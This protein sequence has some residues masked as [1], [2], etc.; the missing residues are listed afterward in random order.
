MKLRVA[1][2]LAAA[3]WN[4]GCHGSNNTTPTPPTTVQVVSGTPQT[5][6]VATAAAAPLVVKVLDENGG[7]AANLSVGFSTRLPASFTPPASTDA[8]GITQ[9]T[10]TA[11][12]TAGADTITATATGSVQSAI[13][14][15]TITPGPPD[16][17]R[18]LAGDGQ[19]APVGTTLPRPFVIDVKDQYL[20]NVVGA[21]VTWTT[22]AGTLSATTS[23]TIE[24]G[25]AQ[26]V[27]TLPNTAGTVRV[28]AHVPGANDVTFLAQAR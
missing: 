6:V 21:Q 27:L 22:D 14:V 17:L 3:A 24:G 15:L 12:T 7:P 28:T 16:T 25:L 20:N 8:N 1:A 5:T 19:I 2:L 4:V 11:G 18:K 23:T 10:V 26:T 13:F 9:T